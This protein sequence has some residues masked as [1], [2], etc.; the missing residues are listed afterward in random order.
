[1]R[2]DLSYYFSGSHRKVNI[3][4]YADDTCLVANYQAPANASCLEWQ[5]GWNGLERQPKYQ[6]IGLQR[7]L[8]NPQLH[9]DGAA[10]PCTGEPVHVLG[11]NVHVPSH[12]M[13]SRPCKAHGGCVC[14]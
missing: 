1:M 9:L 2:I 10:I 3:L 4:Q 13:S 7:K 6:C 8:I 12:N 5:T 14:A 11:L